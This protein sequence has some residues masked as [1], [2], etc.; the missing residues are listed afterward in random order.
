MKLSICIPTYNR[1]ADLKVCLVSVFGAIDAVGRKDT[2]EILV[3]D[4]ASD[5][6]TGDYIKS[7]TKYSDS[8]NLIAWT[9]ETNIGAIRN[10][11][12]LLGSAS[13]KYVFMLT[14]DD[15]LMPNA[16]LVLDGY[17]NKGYSFIKT[18][19]VINLIKSKQC[20]YY[21]TKIDVSDNVN[22]DNFIE[23]MRFSH[24]L[25]GCIVQNSNSLIDALENGNNAYPSLEMCAL[26][27]G[28]CISIAEPIVFHQWENVISWDID[29]DMTSEQSRIR[30][31]NRDMQLAMIHLADNFLDEEQVRHLYRYLLSR[32][33]YIESALIDKFKVPAKDEIRKF[34]RKLFLHSTSSKVRFFIKGAIKTLAIQKPIRNLWL[35]A[36]KVCRDKYNRK[37][38]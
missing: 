31:L 26:S 34:N 38:H 1:L 10:V 30:H 20:S 35:R 16:L 24:V 37:P 28:R 33:S 8:Y 9:N 12:K 22:H 21:G 27:A 5:D 7:L 17:L 25:S 13:G 15:Y 11:K 23:I 3:S 32:C 29:V 19:I 6:G 18:A 36:L 4:N 2:F 14:D